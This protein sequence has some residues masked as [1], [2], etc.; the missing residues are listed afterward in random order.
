ML[1]ETSWKAVLGGIICV[2]EFGGFA[3]LNIWG[4]RE[5]YFSSLLF[6]FPH[7]A[8]I[9]MR[10]LPASGSTAVS[11]HTKWQPG[12][13]GELHSSLARDLRMLLEPQETRGLLW[14]WQDGHCVNGTRWEDGHIL[15]RS[16]AVFPWAN[17]MWIKTDVGEGRSSIL[18]KMD[19]PRA[20]SREKKG[21]Y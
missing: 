19:N 3:H 6:F 1:D 11:Q 21:A 13:P 9:L 14:S 4:E 8:W 17:W 18:V 16:R 7:R 2:V 12:H 15:C 5:D 10:G 20:F